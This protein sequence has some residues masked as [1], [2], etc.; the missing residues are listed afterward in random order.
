MPSQGLAELST[1]SHGST[2]EPTLTPLFRTDILS[3]Q[4]CLVF[5]HSISAPT[6]EQAGRGTG[7]GVRLSFLPLLVF[8]AND[9]KGA[10]P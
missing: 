6:R 3:S 2:I 8:S 1:V 5:F 9:A 4:H 10:E 7:L